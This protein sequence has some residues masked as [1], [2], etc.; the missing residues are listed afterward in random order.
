MEDLLRALPDDRPVT[1]ICIVE[2]PTKCPPGFQ[3]VDKT[4]DQD[5]D[6]D[7]WKDGFF[8]RRITRYICLSKEQGVGSEIVESITVVGEKDSPPDGFILLMY[9]QDSE[10]RATRKKHLCYKL[11]PKY[12]VQSA[13]T[14]IIVL[15]K[16][17]KPPSG[18]TSAGELNSLLI[19]YKL[20]K[21]SSPQKQN[22]NGGINFVPY[23][24]K[25][26]TEDCDDDV[27]SSKAP[28]F[29]SL[30]YNLGTRTLQGTLGLSSVIDDIPFD[31][32][33]RYKDVRRLTEFVMPNITIKSKQ[34][35]DSEY[36]YD[37]QVEK[38]AQQA[39]PSDML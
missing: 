5:T 25:P 28:S 29:P 2:D 35:L 36:C 16:L 23:P 33:P 20:G 1:A 38:Q 22:S 8:G 13:V 37:F 18:F 27:T 10:Q 26:A 21:V 7:L 4:F 30:N 14:D 31:I 32:N 15:S 17:K 11:V 39:I 12:K 6:A 9:T 3:V 24:V 34:Q 19:C